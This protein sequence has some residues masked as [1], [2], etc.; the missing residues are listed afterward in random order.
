MK[1]SAKPRFGLRVTAFLLA[2]MILAAC[3]ACSKQPHADT[4]AAQ[5]LPALPSIGVPEGEDIIPS[6]S[7]ESSGPGSATEETPLPSGSSAEGTTVPPETK[8]S[9]TAAQTTEAPAQ[10][11]QPAESTAESRPKTE[12]HALSTEELNA[13]RSKYSSKVNGFGT[14]FRHSWVDANN[15]PTTV[16]NLLAQFKGTD[17]NLLAYCSDVNSKCVAFSFQC[18]TEYGH[19]GA[20]LDIL[21]K[22]DVKAT[23]YIIHSYGEKNRDL[24]KRMISEGHDIGSHTYSC[25][26][27]GIA[28]WKLE[29]QM[30]DALKMQRYV[31]ETFGY[32]MTKFNFNSGYWS[33]QAIIMMS[34]MGYQVDFCSC[35]YSDYDPAAT[36]DT[37][38]LISDLEQCLHPGCIYCFH[39]TNVIT[40]T[41]LEPLIKYCLAQGY[42]IVAVP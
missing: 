28:N 3:S 27:G 23:F 40:P 15:R 17:A 41:I 36:F 8:D 25:P 34:R 29:D 35:N 42:R 13:I 16:N 6:R 39:T 7:S 4:S 24:V 21:K 26:S 37:P 11:S 18:G 30:E 12:I 9:E 1:Q 31:Q 19:T 20:V 22:Y 2:G 38:A 33:E 10:P 5:T 14:G 32:T